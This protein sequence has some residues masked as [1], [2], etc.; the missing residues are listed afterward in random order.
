LAL[1]TIATVNLTFFNKEC[2]LKIF[3]IFFRFTIAKLQHVFAKNLIIENIEVVGYLIRIFSYLLN[4]LRKWKKFLY[5]E[6]DK[7]LNYNHLIIKH[8]K[9]Y[10]KQSLFSRFILCDFTNDC[11]FLENVH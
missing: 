1:L 9:F 4:F 8:F 5:C 2:L 6:F 10:L 3:L 7:A 11:Y